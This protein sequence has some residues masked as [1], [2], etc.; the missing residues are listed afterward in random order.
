MNI[1]GLISHNS[2]LGIPMVAQLID[3]D[4]VT[5]FDDLSDRVHSA[6]EAGVDILLI[7]GSLITQHAEFDAVA[8]I[9]GITSLP[10]V[11]F[12]STPM[13]LH[14]QADAVLFLSLISGR[15][16]EYLIGHHVA[17]APLL[18]KMDIEVIPTGYMLVDCG[19][20]TTAQY[21]SHTTPLPFNK[22]EIAA[23]TALAGKMLGL[24]LLYLD[25][26][27]GA[28]Q[29]V[30]P[31]MVSAVKQWT[32]MPL[33]VGGGIRTTS[34]AERLFAAGADVL[35]IGNGAWQKPALIPSICALKKSGKWKS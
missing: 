33:M 2:E 31:D 32:G 26:G 30:N 25:G 12:P 21:I 20:A 13:Q 17:A 19:P 5:H 28:D 35:V 14:P 9:K 24:Q 8:A 10:V 11:T 29:P 6:E 22:P 16:P 4:D 3:P 23:A 34:E 1:F 18:R 7:G 27:S 15:N